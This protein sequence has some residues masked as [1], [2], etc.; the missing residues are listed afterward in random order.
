[1]EIYKLP[2]PNLVNNPGGVINQFGHALDEVI[3][4]ILAI[5]S[6]KYL[7]WDKARY[8][9]CPDN[10]TPE[11]LWA[12]VK[13][14]RRLSPGRIDTPVR[15]EKNQY[16]SWQYLPGMEQFLH[17]VDME[18]GGKISW[19]GIKDEATRKKLIA[20]GIMEEA[21]A[22]SQLEG[23]VTTRKVARKMII[24]QRQPTTHSEKMILNNFKAINAIDERFKDEDLTQSMLWELHRILTEG[25]L[26]DESEVGRFRRDDDD[27]VVTDI[28]DHTIYHVPPKEEFLIQELRRLVEFAND[29]GENTTFIHPVVKAIILHFWIG[30][31]HPFTDGNGRVARAIMYWYLLKN[32]YRAFM[33]MPLS[34][35][36]KKSFKQYPMAY[37]YT[38]QDAN[39]F[40]YFLDYMVRK[41][42]QAKK[43]FEDYVQRKYD[44]NQKIQNV[45]DDKYN[46]N[47]RQILLLRYLQNNPNSTT[48]IKTYAL[49]HDIS[50]PTAERDLTTMESIG[51]L[52]SQKVGTKRPFSATTML[53][54]LFR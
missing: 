5:N 37:V 50:R 46:L 28:E 17:E 53:T 12:L 49:I 2:K 51:L 19:L 27:I 30:Y 4:Y 20:R 40:T 43:E 34:T 36:I 45:I 41:F 24:E 47:D 15:D 48:T 31:L 44:E 39:D 33:F 1:M 26:D 11:E 23:A 9:K 35:I 18:L 42:K 6:P 13:M 8:Q 7:Y 25:T 52:G 3:P 10:M 32:N 21:I 54:D 16:F 14:T 38:E 22:S 29:K